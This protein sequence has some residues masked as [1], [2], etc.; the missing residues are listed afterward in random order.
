MKRTLN[1]SLRVVREIRWSH[2]ILEMGQDAS[3]CLIGA[4]GRKISSVSKA[5]CEADGS[6]IQ[7]Q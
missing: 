5:I 1:T 4:K 7:N 2:R 6:P 3:V